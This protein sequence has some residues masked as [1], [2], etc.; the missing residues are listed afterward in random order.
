MALFDSAIFDSVIFDVGGAVLSNATGTYSS[1]YS[2]LNSAIGTY[3]V[4]NTVLNGAFG[5]Y[6]TSNTVLNSATGSYTTAFSVLA[7]DEIISR[8]YRSPTSTYR[9]AIS[10]RA[11][12]KPYTTKLD[13]RRE[14]EH[15]EPEKALT[16]QPEIDKISG[17]LAKFT[18]DVKKTQ[19]HLDAIKVNDALL[20][21]IRLKKSLL[22]EKLAFIE[23]IRLKQEQDMQELEEIALLLFDFV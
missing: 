7:D 18:V 20:V 23:A 22:L 5:T 14:Q 21:K 17:Y 1:S 4:G 11:E 12:D 19:K 3:S 2:V 6:S 13:R 9:T 8:V 10:A 16:N 15:L